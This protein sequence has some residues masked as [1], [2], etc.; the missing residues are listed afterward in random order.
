[1]FYALYCSDRAPAE[2]VI[3]PTSP[4]K[5]IDLLPVVTSDSSREEG[6]L[7]VPVSGAS[8]S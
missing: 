8:L 2:C 3:S 7:V 6:L 4:S 1:M 5:R